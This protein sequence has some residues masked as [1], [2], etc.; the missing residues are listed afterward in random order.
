MTSEKDVEQAGPISYPSYRFIILG[1]LGL[2]NVLN[3]MIV[4]SLGILLPSITEDLGLSP[5][6]Q[7]WLGSSMFLGSVFLSLPAGL[8]LSRFSAKRVLLVALSLGSMC[9]F[10]QSWA[11]VFGVL[12]LGRLAFGVVMVAR[13]PPRAILT[14]QWFPRREVVMVNGLVNSTYGLSAVI[15]FLLTPYLLLWLDN[16][17]RITLIVYGI[18][19]SVIAVAWA[20]AGRE[21]RAAGDLHVSNNLPGASLLRSA[22]RHKE[23]WY[24]SIGMLGVLIM[25]YAL[26]TFWPTLML[27]KYEIPLTTTGMMLFLAAVVEAV[28]S[29]MLA[30]YLMRLVKRE[31]RRPL[32]IALVILLVGSAVGMMLTD[33]IPFLFL[34]VILHGLGFS[35]M[36]LVW[37]IPFELPGMTSREI[38]VASGLIETAARGGGVAGPIIAGF[39]HE[40][41]GDLAFSLVITSLFGLSMAAAA[42][43][44]YRKG[45]DREAVSTVL[46]A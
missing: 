10:L 33:S 46:D 17:W 15:I 20:I 31:F 23:L 6:E 9:V 43:M 35:F 32:V 11:P 24:M 42:M 22:V 40:A 8:W 44:L 12:L 13:Q 4:L 39:L 38:A 3:S 27:E 7:G 14:A 41:S 16:S 36:P 30:I 18:A 34:L 21:R 28:G 37:T 1:F 25:E 19:F 45:P 5:S 2:S 26:F 29:M